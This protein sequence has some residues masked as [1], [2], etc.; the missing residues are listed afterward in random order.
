M[1]AYEDRVRGL[2]GAFAPTH[3][4]AIDA[5]WLLCRLIRVHAD[6]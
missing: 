2:Q 3:R 1:Y 4:R 6:V 5:M